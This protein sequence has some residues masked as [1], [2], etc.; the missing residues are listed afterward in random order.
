MEAKKLKL[1]L[2]SDPVW[3]LNYAIGFEV[4]RMEGMAEA[5]IHLMKARFG[6]MPDSLRQRVMR[7]TC[8]QVEEL[9]EVLLDFESAADLRRWLREQAGKN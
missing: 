2:S 3:W 4:G 8:L 6:G 1:A 9:S 7:L 5:A